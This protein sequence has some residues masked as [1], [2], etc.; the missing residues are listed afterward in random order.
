[1]GYT[2]L[3]Q[4]PENP[5]GFFPFDGSD[6]EMCRQ[7]YQFRSQNQAVVNWAC[8]LSDEELTGYRYRLSDPAKEVKMGGF[9]A[10]VACNRAILNYYEKQ[11]YGEAYT[12][13]K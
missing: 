10:T 13:C 1:M 5:T 4:D 7:Y 11:L 8:R 3:P 9:F 2:K 12:E 6:Q